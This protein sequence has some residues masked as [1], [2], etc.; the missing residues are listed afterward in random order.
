MKHTFK[1]TIETDVTLNYHINNA[2]CGKLFEN[3][4]R[5]KKKQYLSPRGRRATPSNYPEICER[6]HSALERHI[7]LIKLKAMFGHVFF[8][9]A[10]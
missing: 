8:W 5:D 7:E 2:E 6:A 3:T 9:A 1:K 4:L 10:A